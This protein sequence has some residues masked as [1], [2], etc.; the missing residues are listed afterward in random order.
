MVHK[1]GND[2]YFVTAN[3]TLDAYV[4]G[5][6]VLYTYTAYDDPAGNPGDSIDRTVIVTYVPPILS[7]YHAV[8]DLTASAASD[9]TDSTT[10]DPTDYKIL[11]GAR[12]IETVE[13]D[14]STYAIVA[15]YGNSGVQ[16]INITNPT[17][18]ESVSGLHSS[19]GFSSLGSAVDTA[20]FKIDGFTYVLIIALADNAVHIINITNPSSP[21]REDMLSDN[22]NILLDSPHGIDVVEIDGNTYALVTSSTESGMEIIDITD[23]TSMQSVSRISNT[24]A[25]HTFVSDVSV[26][27]IGYHTYALTSFHAASSLYIINIT[28]PGSPETVSILTDTDYPHLDRIFRATPIHIGGYTYAVTTSNGDNGIEIIDI[29]DPSSPTSV[30]SISGTSSLKFGF[31]IN[32]IRLD[33]ESFILASLYQSNTVSIIN[34]TNPNFPDTVLSIPNGAEYPELRGPD[35]ITSVV[36]DD[37]PYVLVASRNGDGVQIIQLDHPATTTPLPNL[38]S[39]SNANSSSYARTGDTITVQINANSDINSYHVS[40]LD[41]AINPTVNHNGSSLNASVNVPF[42]SALGDATF[43]I[44]ISNSLSSLVVTENIT[45]EVIPS[46]P[47]NSG[48]S[49]PLGILS[50]VSGK[51][52]F[53]MFIIE[54]VLLWYNDARMNDSPSRR[55]V[56]MPNP[57][58]SELVPDID[59]TLVGDEGSVM[60]MISIPLSPFDVVTA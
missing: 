44:T 4:L 8:Y 32:T 40:I 35:G 31:G 41:P 37:S 46:G 52:G 27:Q 5:Q 43:N 14:G 54:T 10:D 56:L 59:E 16:I 57:N 17:S 58:F 3:D 20:T 48:Y 30:S 15:A 55:I 12:S 36:I 49:A 2:H 13:I 6:A 18:P 29:T 24:T 11:Y 23:P 60:S 42:N 26:V 33:G 45:T 53:V 38:I 22:A 9:I 39:S 1:H 47:L 7:L 19:T 51:F 21:V 50:T 25:G 28:I 34:M